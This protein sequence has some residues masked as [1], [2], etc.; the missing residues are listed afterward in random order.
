M[1]GRI[2]S[3]LSVAVFNLILWWLVVH[4]VAEALAR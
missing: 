3:Y 1:T 2:L 4:G